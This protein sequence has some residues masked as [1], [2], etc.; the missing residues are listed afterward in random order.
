MDRLS[1]EDGSEDEQAVAEQ[2]VASMQAVPPKKAKKRGGDKKRSGRV[3]NYSVYTREVRAKGLVPAGMAFRDASGWIGAQWAKEPQEVKDDYS[4]KADEEQRLKDLA[5]GKVPC[6][7]EAKRKKSKKKKRKEPEQAS[8]EPQ[9]EKRPAPPGPAPLL[10]AAPVAAAAGT[11]QQARAF[12]EA[13]ADRWR[14]LS[15]Y[16]I[17]RK[18]VWQEFRDNRAYQAFDEQQLGGMIHDRW[19]ELPENMRHPYAEMAQA[20]FSYSMSDLLS[21][22]SST[23][24]LPPVTVPI[25]QSK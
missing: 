2:A 12:V 4:R 16:E 10:P 1:D 17:Y 23:K 24:V 15:A 19:R 25:K 3:S 20:H 21:S 18:S 14:P 9:P 22:S 11:Q 7:E 6:E 13:A 5:Q 8:L